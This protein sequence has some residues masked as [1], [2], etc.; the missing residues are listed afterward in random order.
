MEFIFKNARIIV[1]LCKKRA[2]QL[3]GE[4]AGGCRPTGDIYRLQIVEEAKSGPSD[5]TSDLGPVD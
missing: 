1:A 2:C 3:C 4:E 5:A